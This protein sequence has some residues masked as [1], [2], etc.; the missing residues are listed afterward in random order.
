VERL[1]SVVRQ[2][3]RHPKHGKLIGRDCL[4]VVIHPNTPE[5][6]AYYH[7]EKDVAAPRVPHLVTPWY[8]I[9][10]AK[11]YSLSYPSEQTRQK[12]AERHELRRRLAEYTV[13]YYDEVRRRVPIYG[14]PDPEQIPHFTSYGTTSA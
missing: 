9:V 7:P 1:V 2:A 4:S 5:M 10:D 3:S 12:E 11:T 8:E 6:P 13:A 14:P